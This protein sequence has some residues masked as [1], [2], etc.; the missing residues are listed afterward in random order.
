MDWAPLHLK[1]QHVKQPLPQL[2]APITPWSGGCMWPGPLRG[3]VPSVLLPDRGQRRSHHLGTGRK[4][5]GSAWPQ[6]LGLWILP[7]EKR[8]PAT[9]T[10]SEQISHSFLPRSSWRGASGW[11]FS[12]SGRGNTRGEAQEQR[13]PGAQAALGLEQR[14]GWP[15]G[16][17][18][19]PRLGG[20]LRVVPTSQDFCEDQN[21]GC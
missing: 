21:P 4:K 7:L 3:Q 20:A 11:L 13:G 9:V 6:P 16:P 10:G 14:P 8:V 5:S 12:L 15:A 17:A 1:S 2:A 19:A 18:Q